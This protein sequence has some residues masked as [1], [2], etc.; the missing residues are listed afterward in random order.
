M[1]HGGAQKLKENER[2]NKML[3]YDKMWVIFIVFSGMYRSCIY[4]ALQGSVWENFIGY[5]TL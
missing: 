2:E 5:C 4:R 3:A 1:K